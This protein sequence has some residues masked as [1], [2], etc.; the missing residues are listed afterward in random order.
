MRLSRPA[1]C[2]DTWG[3]RS[4]TFSQLAVAVPAIVPSSFAMFLHL[5]PKMVSRCL[6]YAY[7]SLVCSGSGTVERLWP[8]WQCFRGTCDAHVV[9]CLIHAARWI[10]CADNYTT[11][12]EKHLRAFQN[13]PRNPCPISCVVFRCWVTGHGLRCSVFLFAMLSCILP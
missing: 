9:I 10:T 7:V 5:R 13:L 12:Y 11:A 4:G 8:V 6:V 1:S 2:I 3:T